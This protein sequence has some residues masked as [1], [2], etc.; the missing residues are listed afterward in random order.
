MGTV[1]AIYDQW[2]NE[3]LSLHFLLAVT[4]QP[5]FGSTKCELLSLPAHHGGLGVIDI[6]PIAYF[7]S[8]F[9]TSSCVAAP[10]VGHLLRQRITCSLDVYQLSYVPEQ[11]WIKDLSLQWFICSGTLTFWTF[12][13]TLATCLWSSLRARCIVLVNNPSHCWAWVR[14]TQRKV[15]WCSVLKIRIAAC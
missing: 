10:L 15:L 6:I 12:V 7:S 2:C 14:F 5:A 3:V 1:R 11:V 8:S 9:L 13:S 4:G